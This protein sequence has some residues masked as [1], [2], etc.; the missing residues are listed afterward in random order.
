MGIALIAVQSDGATTTSMGS[1]IL[2][3]IIC[4]M[5][6]AALGIIALGGGAYLLR[7]RSETNAL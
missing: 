2:A 5:P 7:T 3:V 6:I 4:P 1:F